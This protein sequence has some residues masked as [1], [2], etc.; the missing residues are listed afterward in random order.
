MGVG[1]A[2][3]EEMVFDRGRLLNP[4]FRDYKVLTAPP[5]ALPVEPV[6]VEDQE[7]EAGPFRCQGDRGAWPGAHGPGHRQRHL[8]RG[9]DPPEGASHEAGEGAPGVDGEGGA[10]GP[11]GRQ[12]KWPGSIECE[13]RQR[14]W[15]PGEGHRRRT[16][17]SR[18]VLNALM[19][20]S[21][22]CRPCFDRPAETGTTLAREELCGSVSA[23]TLI[24]S[25]SRPQLLL[26]SRPQNHLLGSS[27]K[28][29]RSGTW[30]VAEGQRENDSLL[31]GTHLVRGRCPPSFPQPVYADGEDLLALDEQSL[32]R[33]VRSP[34][35]GS[36][37]CR[38]R[39]RSGR[40]CSPQGRLRS[41]TSG[42]GRPR[43]SG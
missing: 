12:S 2:L 34:R 31:D 32:V 6:I 10:V 5:T 4:N 16:R 25:W 20:C 26:G 37:G 41:D 24:C 15:W 40:T 7:D 9:G 21:G 33:E 22:R 35:S 29:L 14:R 36:T 27:D 3:T 1:Y 11:V 8:R 30:C 38:K 43:R 17:R 42:F 23:R 39:G 18:A 28:L 13:S 19:A